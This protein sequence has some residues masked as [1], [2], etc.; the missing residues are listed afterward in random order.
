MVLTSSYFEVS[1][2][3]P[4]CAAV[5][6]V[7]ATLNDP[8]GSLAKRVRDLLVT[9]RWT[10]DSKDREQCPIHSPTNWL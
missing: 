1:C 2:R 7:P 6:R 9:E 8:A 10:K 3:V 4:E 5:L